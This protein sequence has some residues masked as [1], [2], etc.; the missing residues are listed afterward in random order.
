[1]N[2]PEKILLRIQLIMF[3]CLLPFLGNSQNL[4]RNALPL[5]VKGTATLFISNDFTNETNSIYQNDA[6]VIINGNITNK[7]T[8]TMTGTGTTNITGS[9]AQQLLGNQAFYT[10]NLVLNNTSAG[11]SNFVFNGTNNLIVNNSMTFTDGIVVTNTNNLTMNSGSTYSGASNTSHINGF[12]QKIGNQTFTFPVGDGATLR[13]AS[14]SA[15]SVATDAFT[16]K[17]L[18]TSANPLY[19][20]SS[21]DAVLD[22]LSTCEYWTIDRTS[23]TTDVDVTLS[24][25]NSSPYD[26]LGAAVPTTDYY[27][28][29][30]NGT[31]WKSFANGGTTGNAAAGTV[32]SKTKPTLY[33][34]FILASRNIPLPIKLQY[35]RGENTME[36]NLLTWKTISEINTLKFEIRKSC[37]GINWTVLSETKAKNDS[38]KTAEYS[39]N[40]SDPCDGINYYQLVE[41]TKENEGIVYQTIAIY[42]ENSYQADFGIYPNPNNGTFMVSIIGDAPQYDLDII[43]ILGKTINRYTLI[44]GTNS[45][46]CSYFAAG[47]YIARFRVGKKMITKSITVLQ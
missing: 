6:N 30:W 31:T 45:I 5:Y 23:G 18:Q 39:L 11:S 19:S 3:G 20:L 34:P 36:G 28:G 41:Y 9:A 22:V 21:K 35:F 4:Y 37:D 26:C 12:V 46:D 1:M 8:T 40:D 32:I 43:D 17:Y 13:T 24:W 25:L 27:I 14:I 15:P 38:K 47:V 42:N 7:Q 33:G 44:N 10:Q 2:L 29:G 16:G